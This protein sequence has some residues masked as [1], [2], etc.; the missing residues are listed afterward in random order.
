MNPPL[1][2]LKLTFDENSG[3]PT[4]APPP[5]SE[6]VVAADSARLLLGTPVGYPIGIPA[7]PLTANSEWIKVCS[8]QG[9]NVLT[10]KTYRKRP[11]PALPAANW[12]FVQKLDAPLPIGEEIG[13]VRADLSRTDAR[14]LGTAYSMANSFGI[15]SPAPEEWQEEIRRSLSVLR[16]GQLLIVS[17]VGEYEELA[18]HELVEDF[19]EAA[20]LAADAGAPIVEL[21]LSC[22][23]TV[24]RRGKD[25][26]PPICESPEDTRQIVTAVRA[27]LPP[28]IK[29]VAKLSYLPRADLEPVVA[30]IADSVDG[31]A[32]I[33]TMQVN[34]VDESGGPAFRGTL[35]DPHQPRPKAG[36]SGIAIRDFALDFV[37]SLAL[38][39]RTHGWQFDI[40]GMGGVMEPH[41]VRA[42]M[43]NGADAVQT[44]TAAVNNPD[45]P[46]QLWNNGHPEPS[47]EERLTGLLYAAL[48]DPRWDF[49]TIDGLANELRL[50]HDV[51][52]RLVEGHPDVARR[53]VLNDHEGRELFTAKN[54]PAT[55]RERLERF[56]WILAR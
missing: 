4:D 17:V 20:C 54:R 29:L 10:T 19:V 21:N 3:G 7:S 55:V 35:L 28:E 36:L 53:S 30:A 47:Q 56:R 40:I 23:N 31:I 13:T 45:L 5:V 9:F 44:A 33:N 43:A 38:M 18:G 6:E 52:L 24:S 41:D 11:T 27:A 34:V 50:S 25:V 32:G 14:G 49:R 2:N 39:R 8:D 22:P 26:H 15:P 12:T 51:V 48:M 42:L 1:Y 16:P 46:R 37:R